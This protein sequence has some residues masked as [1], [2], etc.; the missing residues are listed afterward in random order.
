M[1]DLY[2]TIAKGVLAELHMFS[3]LNLAG[4]REVVRIFHDQRKQGP[5]IDGTRVKS[6]ALSAPYGTRVILCTATE[7]LWEEQPWR[8]L[9]FV[10][11]EKFKMREGMPVIQVPDLDAMD[12]FKAARHDP[13]MWVGYPTVARPD[14]GKG[15]T[16]GKIVFDREIKANLKGLRFDK[17][18]ARKEPDTLVTAPLPI[19]SDVSSPLGEGEAA[20]PGTAPKVKR[21]R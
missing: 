16:Y 15:W 7:A 4:T 11:G 2:W 1:A 12:D 20:G 19:V 17:I 21:K 18:P 5:Q 14:D 9:C 3:G 13:E 8:A 10:E 6:I